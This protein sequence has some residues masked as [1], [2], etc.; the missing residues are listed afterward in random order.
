MN[1]KWPTRRLRCRYPYEPW[2]CTGCGVVTDDKPPSTVLRGL[3]CDRCMDDGWQGEPYI[4]LTVRPVAPKEKPDLRPVV[5]VC[6]RD[7][8]C[9]LQDGTV[10]PLSELPDRVRERSPGENGRAGRLRPGLPDRLPAALIITDHALELLTYLENSA[11]SRS[12]F[13]QWQCSIR[14]VAPWRPETQEHSLE[15][16]TCKPARF[17]FASRRGVRRRAG[18]TAL[19]WTI[20]DPQMFC[21]LPDGWGDLNVAELAKFGVELRDWSN[22]NQLPVC[23]TVSA[24]GARL[25]KDSRFAGGWRRKVPAATND[26]VRKRLPGNHYQLLTRPGRTIPACHKFD[27]ARA[28]HHAAL[29]NRF[30]HADLLDARGAFRAPPPKPGSPF[31][32]STAPIPAGGREWRQLLDHAGMFIVAVHVPERVAIDPLAIPALRTAGTTW[33]LL[34][35]PEVHHCRR[36]HDQGVRL[37][38]IHTAWTSPED[39]D[40]PREYAC[41]AYRQLDQPN[42]PRWLKPLLLSTY[43]MLAARPAR[44]RAAWRWAS[45]T[46]GAIGFETRY[47]PLIGRE[48]S[49][50]RVRETATVNVVWR[51]IIEASVRLESLTFAQH[52]QAHGMRPIA[53]YADA[54]FAV[55]RH[56]PPLLPPPWRH[57]GEL[58]NLV[59]ETPGRYRAAE[60]TRLPGTPRERR[61]LQP[62]NTKK[63]RPACSR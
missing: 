56:P 32:D 6:M 8:Q 34:T 45:R 11:C 53:I 48:R 52:L 7:E 26:R 12:M 16:L 35:S 31:R 17:G 33:Q 3:V 4:P 60:E 15:F 29:I 58:H 23:Q 41:W 42:P 59:F 20:I 47:G 28:H 54:I 51:A 10:F 18:G 43:G 44:F 46:D 38:D 61:Q 30:P 27:Q 9:C 55:G 25:L 40:R 5:A 49:Q 2:A 36:L 39:D 57:D 24:Y 21:D 63:G 50:K 22:A 13:W 62:T 37:L 14:P 1:S 19:W